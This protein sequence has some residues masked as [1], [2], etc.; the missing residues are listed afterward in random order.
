MSNVNGSS[1][2]RIF[3]GSTDAGLNLSSSFGI[4]LLAGGLVWAVDAWLRVPLHL[5]GWRG[6]IVMAILVA[7]RGVTGLPWA[8]TA[9]V[10]SAAVIGFA[11]GNIGPHGVLIYLLPGLILDCFGM[12]GP[13]WRSSLWRI[14][15]SAGV[16]NALK[17]IAVLAFGAGFRGVG[18]FLPLTSHFLFGLAGGSLAAILLMRVRRK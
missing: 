2:Q 13:A 8:A 3:S 18:S 11:A 4:C 16:A 14:G 7:A 17:F 5:P 9:A 10:C 1:P 12:L 15:F 6:L